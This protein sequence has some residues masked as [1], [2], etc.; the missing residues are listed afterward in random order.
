MV[1]VLGWD[2]ATAK[3]YA[4]MTTSLPSGAWK[5]VLWGSTAHFL[6][7][8]RQPVLV[9]GP[10]IVLSFKVSR[11]SFFCVVWNREINFILLYL[12]IAYI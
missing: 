7:E 9:P 11:M 4:V 5:L 10:K 6:I 2:R 1:L 3:K 12:N 8:T